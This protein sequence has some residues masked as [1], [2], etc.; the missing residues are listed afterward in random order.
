MVI[1]T[2][3][4]TNGSNSNDCFT[5]IA[6]A[7]SEWT[8]KK[9]AGLL[10]GLTQGEEKEEENIYAVEPDSGVSSRIDLFLL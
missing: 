2:N 1:M 9:E 6:A 3:T 4:C 8:S 10:E 7:V 5:V